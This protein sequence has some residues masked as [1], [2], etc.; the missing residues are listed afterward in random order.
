MAYTT[1]TKVETF[2][3]STLTAAQTAQIASWIAVADAWINNFTDTTFAQ[4]ATTK[5]YDGNGLKDTFIDEFEGAPT[6]EF[7]DEDGVVEDTLSSD[8]FLTYPLN[9]T[10]KNRLTLADGGSFYTF[11]SGRKRLKITG[12][13][14]QSSVPAPVELASTMLTAEIIK[15]SMAGGSVK[16]ESLGQYSIT[17]KDIDDWNDNL[18]IKNLLIP[19]KN[20]S[21]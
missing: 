8:D 19:Y 4:S 13:F 12:N 6:V 10:V 5:Y 2:L 16:A 7:L 20:L 17:F 14:G 21:V 11:P 9:A 15:R 1:S 3:G 18:G